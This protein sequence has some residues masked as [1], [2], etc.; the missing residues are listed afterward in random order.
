MGRR[1]EFEQT[2][3]IMLKD[4]KKLKLFVTFCWTLKHEVY[5]MKFGKELNDE[6]DIHEWMHDCESLFSEWS[7]HDESGVEFS[8]D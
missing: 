2:M 6:F 8:I 5:T 3:S 7:S 1:I 4:K